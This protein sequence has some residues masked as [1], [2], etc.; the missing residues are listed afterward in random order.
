MCLIKKPFKTRHVKK[1]NLCVR[2]FHFYSKFFDKIV[3]GKNHKWF[4]LALVL[5]AIVVV[6]H[7]TLPLLCYSATTDKPFWMYFVEFVEVESNVLS[8]LLFLVNLVLFPSF[9]IDLWIQ[10]VCVFWN[11]TY[12]ELIRPQYYSYLFTKI[13]DTVFY[14]NPNHRG[15]LTNIRRA[16]TN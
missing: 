12:D 13:N 5:N 2:D 7:L 6:T 9:M 1:L 4:I 3:F 16:F 8:K 11:L 15:F 10:A 14:K